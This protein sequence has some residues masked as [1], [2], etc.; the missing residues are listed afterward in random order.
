MEPRKKI[1]EDE[2]EKFKEEIAMYD[3]LILQLSQ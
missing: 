3:K 1:K 2:F